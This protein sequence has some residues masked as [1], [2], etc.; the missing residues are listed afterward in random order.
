M[1]ALGR[2]F[3]AERFA[4]AAVEFGGD[5]G[6]VLR[7]RTDRSVLLGKYCRSRPFVFS[8]EPR[9]QGL[10]G[11]QKETGTSVAIVNSRDE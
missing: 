5:G 9:C 6:Q 11:S 7:V 10:A 2:G 3:P 8:F 1:Q 4:W